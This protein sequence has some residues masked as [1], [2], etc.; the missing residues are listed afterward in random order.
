MLGLDK[1]NPTLS[2][3]PNTFVNV[4]IAHFPTI[5]QLRSAPT[6]EVERVLLRAVVEYCADG[7]HPM[8]TRDTVPTLLLEPGGYAYDAQAR[9]DLGRV[10]GRAW[11]A[12]EDASFIEEPDS[13]NGKNGFRVPSAEGRK[14]CAATDYAGVRMRTKFTRDMFHPS[15][16]DTAWNAF[17]VGDYDTAIFEAFKSLEVAVR[18]KGGFTSADF[19]AAL[20]KKAFDANNGPLRDQSA[21]RSRRLARCDLFTGAFGEIRNP[22]GHNDP[23][24]TDTLVAV[25]ELMTAGMLRRIVDNA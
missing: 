4:I 1:T 21:Q 12:L 20:M 11:K 8:I 7:M 13:Y 18:T 6:L 2:N 3:M 5:A 17:S 16:P 14:A 24:I 25:E 22:K 15:L 19:G 23:T 9:S 10:V